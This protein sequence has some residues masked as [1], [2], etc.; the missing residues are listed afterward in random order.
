LLAVAGVFG[1]CAGRGPGPEPAAEPAVTVIP[2]D[3]ADP[4]IVLSGLTLT[5]ECR[6]SRAVLGDTLAFDIVVSNTGDEDILVDNGSLVNYPT[7][8]EVGGGELDEWQTVDILAAEPGVEAFWTV[9]ARGSATIA[10]TITFRRDVWTGFGVPDGRYEGPG[11]V[12]S[13][14]AGAAVFAPS[15]LPRSVLVTEHWTAD[16]DTVR[17]RAERFGLRRVFAG[18]IASN[19]VEVILVER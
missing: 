2:D 15:A 13:A 7:F 18:T 8:V 6:T 1:G 17:G 16:P 12:V 4:T 3:G 11:L 9:P 19:A 14:A 10:R 5:L